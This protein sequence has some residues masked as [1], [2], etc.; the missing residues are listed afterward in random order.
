MKTDTEQQ[1]KQI[2]ATKVAAAATLPAECINYRANR[3]EAEDNREETSGIIWWIKMQN[4]HQYFAHEISNDRA[5]THIF[6]CIQ[7]ES[8]RAKEREKE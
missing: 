5:P 4:G 8:E 3:F 7:R 6:Y 2:V 1:R